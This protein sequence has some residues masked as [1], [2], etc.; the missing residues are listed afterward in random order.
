MAIFKVQISQAPA[1]APPRVL[2]YNRDQ[3]V[4]FQGAA[5]PELI[6]AMRGRAKAFFA[7]EVGADGN[8]DLWV[9]REMPDPGW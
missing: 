5:E 3:S 1:D 2:V 8:L 6:E 9:R 4:W 7:G